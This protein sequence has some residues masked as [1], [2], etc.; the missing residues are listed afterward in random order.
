MERE[1]LIHLLLAAKLYIRF[2]SPRSSIGVKALQIHHVQTKPLP[3][4]RSSSHIP[5][6]CTCTTPNALETPNP[7]HHTWLF[8]LLYSFN[9]Q[10]ITKNCVFYFINISHSSVTPGSLGAS[11]YTVPSQMKVLL[12]APLFAN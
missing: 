3:L 10:S 5:H 4:T 2:P 8:P 1:W 7:Q 11:A 9:I 12:C 6:H